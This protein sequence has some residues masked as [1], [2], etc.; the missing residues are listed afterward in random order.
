M[1]GC[2]SQTKPARYNGAEFKIGSWNPG[3]LRFVGAWLMAAI[4]FEDLELGIAC[5]QEDRPW[6]TTKMTV[7]Q[8]NN[9]YTYSLPNI[10][11][12]ALVSSWTQQQYIL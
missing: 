2:V 11:Y 6:E 12:Y 4:E 1:D 10:K 5:V 3:S 7:V 8:M 9:M